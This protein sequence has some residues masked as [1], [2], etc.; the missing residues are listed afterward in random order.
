MAEA[1]RDEPRAASCFI[2][3]AF[4]YGAARPPTDGERAWLAGVEAE[5]VD[6]GVKWR[7]LMRRIARHPD[8]YT[9]VPGAL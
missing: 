5:L 8:F 3:R 4:S 6:R 2:E 1:L 7:D 9:V